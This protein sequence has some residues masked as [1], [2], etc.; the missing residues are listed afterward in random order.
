MPQ[1]K[2]RPQSKRTNAGQEQE[3]H[4]A[5]E[6][7]VYLVLRDPRRILV[8]RFDQI[9]PFFHKVERE[10]FVN[11]VARPRLILTTVHTDSP[12]EPSVIEGEK[13][14]K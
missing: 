4:G 10:V 3:T 8:D 12:V 2:V 6:S 13:G 9:K 11:P 1:G 14:R 7:N 5:V